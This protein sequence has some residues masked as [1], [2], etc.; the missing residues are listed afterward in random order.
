[1]GRGIVRGPRGF[2]GT[3]TEKLRS[4]SPHSR[5]PGGTQDVFGQNFRSSRA[6]RIRTCDLLVP[7]HHGNSRPSRLKSLE[8]QAFLHAFPPRTRVA[9][10]LTFQR[11]LAV[12]SSPIQYRSSKSLSRT[13]DPVGL[14]AELGRATSPRLSESNCAA[15]SRRFA[16]SRRCDLTTTAAVLI[17]HAV[18][19]YAEVLQR[20]RRLQQA[21]TTGLCLPVLKYQFDRP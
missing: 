21:R 6:D 7:K 15:M 4:S 10:R 18:D 19:R 17:D 20:P 12:Q 9:K 8:L 11:F 13:T 14:K 1:M 16:T 5:P 3:C 2:F